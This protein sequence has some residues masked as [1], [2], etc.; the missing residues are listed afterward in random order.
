MSSLPPA[1]SGGK[2][3]VYEQQADGAYS[4]SSPDDFINVGCKKLTAKGEHGDG[5]P[6]KTGWLYKEGHVRK[7]WK[8]R[9]FVLWPSEPVPKLGQLLL[10]YTDPDGGAP[11]GII[12]LCEF[13]IVTPK[14]Q[15]E[16]EHCFR[17]TIEDYVPQGSHRKYII[18][19]ENQD[20]LL[21][22]S[23]A[24]QQNTDWE[25][26]GAGFRPSM[27][28]K[29]TPRPSKTKSATPPPK[30]KGELVEAGTA[31]AVGMTLDVR[32]GTGEWR[33]VTVVQLK[34]AEA[35]DA[36]D[37]EG[38]AGEGAK[39]KIYYDGFKA[40]YD[41]WVA[42]GDAERVRMETLRA[43]YVPPP[44]TEEEEFV[45]RAAAAIAASSASSADGG[46]GTAHLPEEIGG[47]GGRSSRAA[48]DASMKSTSRPPSTSSG[49]RRATKGDFEFEHKI[50]KGAFADVVTAKRTKDGKLFAVK[51]LD[52]SHI[53]RNNKIK[54]VKIER[55]VLT[56]LNS[57]YVV[58]LVSTFQ[59][60][61]S[62]YYVMEYWCALPV[63][64]LLTLTRFLRLTCV[65]SLSSARAASCCARSSAGLAG[66]RRW[67]TCS[68]GWRSW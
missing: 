14:T 53:I 16:F 50:G 24:I 7:N 17:I 25:S 54:Y 30:P 5:W 37:A 32:S 23:T 1:K 22:W 48:S 58:R 27:V 59:D 20:T 63:F 4:W 31:A 28:G 45:A 62:L 65:P 46:A 29:A 55:D 57:P 21:E 36:G 19:S 26:A 61:D 13:N 51:V 49:P 38:E 42:V 41:E 60:R 68:F 44:L 12:P 47:G 2:R 11:K 6:A 40:E 39:L 33:S 15:R 35:G 64:L 3:A 67:R 18:A 66:A 9:F 8:R 43:E 56:L 34:P 52:K 10:Y